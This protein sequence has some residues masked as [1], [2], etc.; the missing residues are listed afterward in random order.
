MK[1]VCI[2]LI[3]SLFV[4][5]SF[6]QIKELRIYQSSAVSQCHFELD[7]QQLGNCPG[8]NFTVLSSLGVTSKSQEVV[9]GFQGKESDLF[10]SFQSRKL[11]N[12]TIEFNGTAQA[13]PTFSCILLLDQQRILSGHFSVNGFDYQLEVD[14]NQLFY[15]HSSAIGPSKGNPDYNL[16]SA[17]TSLDDVYLLTYI[18]GKEAR[19][20]TYETGIGVDLN[21]PIFHGCYDWHSAIHG[22]YAA[23]FTGVYTNDPG[24]FV[25]PVN[26]QFTASNVQ[27]EISYVPSLSALETQYGM[28]WLLSYN[29]YL[30]TTIYANTANPLTPLV[31]VC[32]NQ[33]KNFVMNN[34][35]SYSVYYN[36]IDNG[37]RNYN[38]QLLN[39][40][41]HAKQ[42][43]DAVTMQYVIDKVNDY[44]PFVNWNNVSSSEFY[45]AR[46]IAI[47]LYT[48]TGLTNGTHWD[49]LINAYDNSSTA[50]PYNVNTASSHRVGRV[51]SYAHGYWLMY[52]HTCDTRY[53]DAFIDHYDAIFQLCKSRRFN[54]NYFGSLGHWVPNFGVFGF[55]LMEAYP[56]PIEMDIRFLLE[57]AYDSNSGDMTTSLN[58]VHQVL[59]GMTNSTSN[60]QPYSIAPWNY[61]GTEGQGWSNADYSADAV[62]WV[63]LSLR[64]DIAKSSEV[65]QMAGVLQDN[66]SV[67][68]P[69]ICKTKTVPDSDYYIVVEHRNHMVAMSPSPIPITNRRLTWDF[70]AQN[71]Y[72]VG[73]TG[74]KQLATGVWALV[75]GDGNQIVDQTSYDVNGIDRLLWSQNNGF[76]KVYM[77]SDFNMDSD[78]S[79]ADKTIWFFNNGLFSAVPK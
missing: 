29:Q 46:A 58:T 37:Y 12:G 69:D 68:W 35:N 70:S 13:D 71:S 40:Y 67:V 26:N 11:S 17:F 47:Q 56:G 34:L 39:L 36:S 15:Y 63:L 78:V 76:S 77:S 62:D 75:A 4:N 9:L 32:Y 60:G 33:A 5:Y 74:Q 44:A 18:W 42:N 65:L 25:N 10:V 73:S 31:N 79:G 50:I 41:I 7:N 3:L 52:H 22:H 49:N 53:L 38:W 51:I 59:P 28:P 24:T 57:G 1:K 61:S 43:G 14:G 21:A 6:A 45:S 20:C 72:H 16:L 19:N 27:G 2:V 48:A 30:D 64:T 55:R 23:N 66:G 54:S 8:Y